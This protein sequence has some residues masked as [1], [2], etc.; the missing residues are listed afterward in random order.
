M[1]AERQ[2]RAA[3]GNEYIFA[4]HHAQ[5][6]GRNAGTEA[7]EP[8][9][10]D[11]RRHEEGEGQPVL[12]IAVDHVAHR[13]RQQHRQHGDRITHYARTPEG[14]LAVFVGNDV[15]VAQHGGMIHPG[16]GVQRSITGTRGASA[17]NNS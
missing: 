15:F 1:D 17:H 12:Q 11:R 5:R 14:P 8:D 4:E 6:G 2:Q 7:A 16:S 13:K 9:R 10:N 3:R